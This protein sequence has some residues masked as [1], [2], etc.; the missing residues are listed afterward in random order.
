MQDFCCFV[1]GRKGEGGAVVVVRVVGGWGG[2]G[3]VV[4]LSLDLISAS[5]EQI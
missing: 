3:G 4:Q 5:A 2:G 1:E